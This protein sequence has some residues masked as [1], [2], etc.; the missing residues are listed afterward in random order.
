[1][2]VSEPLVEAKQQGRGIISDNVAT[3]DGSN[4]DLF[5]W[6]FLIKGQRT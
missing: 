2:Q 5:Q 1:M 3:T 4:C 6:D